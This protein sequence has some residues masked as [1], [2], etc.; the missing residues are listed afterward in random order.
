[1]T[2]AKKVCLSCKHAQNVNLNESEFGWKCLQCGA[3]NGEV[4]CDVSLTFW[5]TARE[6][7]L[8]DVSVLETKDKDY[9][10]SW[11]NRGGIGAFFS[12]VRK[13]DRIEK[14]C[15]EKWY[16]V[17]DAIRSD[18]RPEGILDDI[19]DLRRY[20]ILVETEM[21]IQMQRQGLGLQEF[22]PEQKS[23]MTA[24]LLPDFKDTGK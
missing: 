20:L 15:R 1:M 23:K 9:G 18:P 6:I 22:T 7:A 11:K 3:T 21:K 5:D 14:A 16:D 4:D 17:F 8:N 19:A 12:F 24:T 2:M 13:W 10:S